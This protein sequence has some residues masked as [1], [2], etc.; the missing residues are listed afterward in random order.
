MEQDEEALRG[1][2]ERVVVMELREIHFYALAGGEVEEAAAVGKGEFLTEHDP[3]PGVESPVQAAA[4][5]ARVH[6]APPPRAAHGTEAPR[7]M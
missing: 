5:P 6:G 1:E 7:R 2:G 3:L 4:V